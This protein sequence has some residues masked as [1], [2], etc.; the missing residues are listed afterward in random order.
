MSRCVILPDEFDVIPCEMF[1]GLLA[2]RLAARAAGKP[3]PAPA[4]ALAPP[5]ESPATATAA[6]PAS[7]LVTVYCLSDNV[8]IGLFTSRVDACE[9]A[10]RVA[11][12]P[13]PH[14]ERYRKL[15]ELDPVFYKESSLLSVDVTEFRGNVPVY[16]F[17]V[18]NLEPGRDYPD[19]LN[20]G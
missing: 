9:F 15:H 10:Y 14:I 19:A 17:V 7:F 5:V 8:P 6:P 13:Q 12:D 18:V 4:V 2:D 20:F 16:R 11:A 3:A 1:L